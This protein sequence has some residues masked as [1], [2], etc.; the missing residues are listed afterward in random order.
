MTLSRPE[1]ARVFRQF[2]HVTSAMDEVVGPFASSAPPTPLSDDDY[3]SDD[4]FYFQGGD[5]GAGGGGGHG[6]GG[7]ID[8][9]VDEDEMMMLLEG[10]GISEQVALR[11]G[12]GPRSWR[13]RR[14]AQEIITEEGGSS[15]DDRAGGGSHGEGGGKGIGDGAH[16]NGAKEVA[17]PLPL[18]V[19]IDA[20]AKHP[21]HERSS[22]GTI[23]RGKGLS[24][25]RR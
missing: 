25:V 20:M 23:F 22:N 14:D 13:A 24:V 3:D 7:R 1:S 2:G 19:L 6:G 5:G 21:A 18:Q 17:W 12:I 11:A 8:V 9:D 4:D 16:N 10:V 15:G